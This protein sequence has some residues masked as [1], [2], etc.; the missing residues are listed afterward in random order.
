M[1]RKFFL[2]A[3]LFLFLVVSGAFLAE[4]KKIDQYYPSLNNENGKSRV[5]VWGDS[6]NK[7]EIQDDEMLLYDY[8][9]IDGYCLIVENNKL[10]KIKKRA[11][12][13][14][15]DY[16]IDG[17]DF[18]LDFDKS[19]KKNEVK[20]IYGEY[21]NV[22]Y[23]N[24][25]S[26]I[27]VLD[28]GSAYPSL[29]EIDFVEQDYYADDEN[30][31][32]TAIVSIIKRTDPRSN[33]YVAKIAD[34]NGNAY[35]SDIIAAIDWAIENDVNIITLNMYSQIEN[36][37]ISPL[38]LA[39]DKAVDS[40]IICIL[41]AGNS[42]D[43]V[44]NFQPANS[45]KAIVV[46]SCDANSIPSSFSN[47]GGDIYAVGEDVLARSI[48]VSRIGESVVDNIVKVSGTSFASAKVTGAVGL[49]KEIN[50]LLTSEEIKEVLKKSYDNVKGDE[51]GRINIENALKIGEFYNY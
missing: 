20:K 25:G 39:I 17:S 5:I 34:K 4:N 14:N 45:D 12:R 32:G 35:L 29:A 21:G 41:P 28:T 31:H 46:M 16:M 13:C 18:E 49:L 15:L 9:I 24:H 43:N 26:K 40:G 36:D 51:T 8:K 48:D 47:K 38:T 3:I 30:G 1:R 22:K 42:A 27:A 10:S 33:I 11:E 44:Q 23:N 2:L 37:I 19:D 6:I 7:F 50:P